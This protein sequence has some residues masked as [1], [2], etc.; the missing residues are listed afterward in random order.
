MATP[1]GPSV[2]DDHDARVEPRFQVKK[3]CG[4]RLTPVELRVSVELGYTG[5]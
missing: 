5:R 4:F 3:V 1:L 2:H